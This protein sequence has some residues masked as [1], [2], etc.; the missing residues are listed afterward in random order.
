MA[1]I[2]ET[3]GQKQAQKRLMHK[4]LGGQTWQQLRQRLGRDDQCA[5]QSRIDPT[6]CASGN[7]GG[8]ETGNPGMDG[9]VQP[10]PSAQLDWVYFTG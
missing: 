6:P 2:P 9:L 7:Q 5:V 3:G 10:S 4:D 1:K 8:N